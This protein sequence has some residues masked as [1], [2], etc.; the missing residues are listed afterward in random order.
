M[1]QYAYLGIMADSDGATF[2]AGL[3]SS[4]QA[5]LSWS[6]GPSEPDSNTWVPFKRWLDTANGI[7][8][9]RNDSNTLWINIATYDGSSLIPI[10]ASGFTTGDVLPSVELAQPSG[11]LFMDSKT[12]GNASSGATYASS[13]YEDLYAF[14]WA[15]YSNTWAP[16][17][18]SGGTPVSRG[19]S[20]AADWASN[21]RLA[22]PDYRG[23]ALVV[24]DN[25]GGSSANR[26][27]DVNADALG[28]RFGAE[29]VTLTTNEIPAHNHRIRSYA[30]QID[31][32]SSEGD[33]TIWTSQGYAD[34]FIENTG[35]GGAHNNLMPSGVI[36]LKI[37]I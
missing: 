11:W 28:G 8:K 24:K 12:M 30:R 3:N 22:L 33:R 6:S 27:T 7:L 15:N 10:G 2:R 1:S 16:M 23:C 14:I 35:G 37:K 4:F 5:V 21:N 32:S 17:T 34:G 26:I 20:A 9:M 31:G 18:S 25:M 19:A 29:T 13:T 36:N